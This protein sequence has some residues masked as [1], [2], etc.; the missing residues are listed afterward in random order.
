YI[1]DTDNHL[2]RRAD[3]GART[4]TTVLGSGRIGFPPDS[5]SGPCRNMDLNSPWDLAIMG[6]FLYIAMAGDHQIW[7]MD[8][9]T[10]QAQVYAGTGEEEIIDG[11]VQ[12]AALAQPSGLAACGK[13]LYIADSEV[14]AIRMIEDDLV[15][16]LIG[17][18][19]FDFGDADGS[20]ADARL[21]HP[22]GV[23][24][25]E[26]A[27]YIADSYNN[28]IKKADLSTRTIDTFIGKGGPGRG[29]DDPLGAG[30]REPNDIAFLDDRF[31]IADTNNHMIR[32]YDPGSRELSELNFGELAPAECAGTDQRQIDL[33][34]RSASLKAEGIRFK[35]EL[36]AGYHWNRDAEQHVEVMSNDTG[37]VSIMPLVREE[38][39]SYL[40]PLKICSP[41]RITLMIGVVAYFCSEEGLCYSETYEFNLPLSVSEGGPE[42]IE[43]IYEIIPQKVP[44]DLRIN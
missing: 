31:Y 17:R 27:L 11:P 2:I 44:V 42:K 21:Q 34:E 20:F 14:S 38:E 8:L 22:L 35:L 25:H 3:L 41:G 29:T 36:P 43:V 1:A 10:L 23:L 18:G 33:K 13:R 9:D 4:V 39:F 6:G 7:R 32:V 28:K 37:S 15:T 16:T 40:I 12:K 5:G 30:L 26:G 19:L 24:C